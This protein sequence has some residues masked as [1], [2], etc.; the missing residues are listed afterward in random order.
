VRTPDRG[1]IIAAATDYIESWL[2]GD[3][4]RM[5]GCL[6]PDLAK[7]RVMDATSGSLDLNEVPFADLVEAAQE[8]K[9]VPRGHQVEVLD[10]AEETASVRVTSHPFV[11]YLHLARFGD[12]WLIVN[13]L[14]E[15]RETR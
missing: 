5:R 1:A 13:A 11:D 6:H 15:R 8:A 12:R 10:M 7:R 4:E 3:A 9:D 2:E 14:Y